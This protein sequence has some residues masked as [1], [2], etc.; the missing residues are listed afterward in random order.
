MKEPLNVCSISK[1][2][3]AAFIVIVFVSFIYLFPFFLGKVDTP[4]DIRDV[5]M[6]PW[7]YHAVDEKI[8]Q[9]TIPKVHDYYINDLIQVFTPF[10]EFYSESIKKLQVPFWNNYIFTGTEFLAEPQVGYFHPVYFLIYFLFDHFTAHGLVTFISFILSG[11][12]AF[13][14]ARYW[15]LG[16]AASLFTAIVYMFQPFNVTWFSY[17]HMLMNSATMPFLLLSY[18]KNLAQPKSLNKYLLISAFLLGLIFLSG[19]LQYIY[20]TVIF[21]LLFA[22]FRFLLNYKSFTKHIFSILFVL[23]FGIIIGSIVLIP[24]F[25]LFLNSHR[26][27]NSLEFIRANSLSFKSLLGLIHPFY[28]GSLKNIYSENLNLD[29]QYVGNFFNHY[30][31]FGFLPLVFFIFSLGKIFSEKLVI[32]FLFVIFLSF[33]ICTGSPVYFLIKDVLPGFKE[34]QHFRFLQLY[35]YSIPFLSGLGF[36]FVLN[37]ISFIKENLKQIIVSSIL[38]VTIFDL[39]YFSSF[40]ITWSDRDAYKPLPQ[41]GALKFLIDEKGKSNEPFR[42]LPFAVDK[43]GEIKLNVNIAQP[44][45]L[46]PYGLEDVSGYSS[47]IP[48]D[49]FNLFVYV[50]TKDKNKLYAKEKLNLFI[51]PN[52][53]FPIYNFKSKIL[54]LLNVKY[55]MVP[56]IITIDPAY[57]TK[58]FDGDCAIYE[59]KDYL[60]RVFFA[61]NYKVIKDPKEI[62]V[63]LDSL[64]FDPEKE[65]ILREE[66]SFPGLTRES[67][68]EKARDYHLDSHFRGNDLM[69]LSSTSNILYDLNKITINAKVNKAAFLVLGNN[70]NDNWKVKVNGIESKHIQAN[71][72]QRAVYLPK[73]GSYLIEFYYHSKLFLIGLFITCFAL[74][75]L[76]VL[77]MLL[78]RR[79]K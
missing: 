55:F 42:I 2:D 21:F 65:V 79:V 41:Q 62:I 15:K 18:E 22:S 57:A 29:P 77:I 59:N 10:R 52:V 26:T 53:P 8:D 3:Q 33:F 34:M 43:I 19:H 47:F 69:D 56:S 37:K 24:F 54:D 30:V 36:Q 70:L 12:G 14:L 5:L 78:N 4:I 76:V 71:L 48:K 58:V 45:T 32:L 73:A 64:N 16:Y 75:V 20:Y 61:E 49:I 6:Y 60:P 11:I 7:R 44:N 38:I 31:Y 39:M 23:L 51:N 1:K 72:V 25:S 63:E 50:Q 66:M 67:S 17:E 9:A 40:F 46:L 13:L 68:R 27:A 35:S 28:G 74:I